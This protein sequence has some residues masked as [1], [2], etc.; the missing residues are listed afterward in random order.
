ML[1]SPWCAPSGVW[2]M[3]LPPTQGRGKLSV[4][5]GPAR[6]PA[7]DG[8]PAMRTLLRRP[9]RRAC[10]FLNACWMDR[11]CCWRANTPLAVRAGHSEGALDFHCIPVR[12]PLR[13]CCG[14][15][16]RNPLSQHHPGP[17]LPSP[18][19]GRR[20]LGTTPPEVNSKTAPSR[21]L[22]LQSFSPQLPRGEMK[23]LELGHDLYVK[24]V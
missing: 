2:F 15:G 4:P 20:N 8:H 21:D 6:S 5:R 9:Q 7:R 12:R 3:I 13:P 10:L 16:D 18:L 22:F 11:R 24:Q 19:R 23:M 17:F 1:P 14:E